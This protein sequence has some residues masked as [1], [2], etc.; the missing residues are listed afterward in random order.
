M[1]GMEK[2]QPYFNNRQL[3]GSKYVRI[4]VMQPENNFGILSSEYKYV[5]YGNN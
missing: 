3:V 1:G 2:S 4:E 5:L